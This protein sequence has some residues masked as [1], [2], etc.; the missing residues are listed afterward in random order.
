MGEINFFDKNN[1]NS[2]YKPKTTKGKKKR[3]F[4]SASWGKDFVLKILYISKIGKIKKSPVLE[5]KKGFN[6]LF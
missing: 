2:I 1:L 4:L 5:K 3:T 6:S